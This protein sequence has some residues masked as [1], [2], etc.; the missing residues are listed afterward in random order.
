MSI[1]PRLLQRPV[2]LGPYPN[3]PLIL[4]A[5]SQDQSAALRKAYRQG[6]KQRE[7]RGSASPPPAVKGGK[8]R[9]RVGKGAVGGAAATVAGV[10]GAVGGGGDTHGTGLDVAGNDLHRHAGEDVGDAGWAPGLL[11][12]GSEAAAP[13]A[14]EAGGFGGP[15][16][17]AGGPAGDTSLAGGGGNL[18]E[19]RPGGVA[20]FEAS[21]TSTAADGAEDGGGGGGGGGLVDMLCDAEL[22]RTDES[23]VGLGVDGDS[24]G[25][26]GD[27][28]GGLD[29]GLGGL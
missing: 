18:D 28:G 12:D 20:N 10:F 3:Q 16:Q 19:S 27:D 7:E 1:A 8:N 9:P 23:G 15:A 2:V 11:H 26:L 4:I 6:A 25:G 29:D 24:V 5:L 14:G 17:A 13:T 22:G 21:T